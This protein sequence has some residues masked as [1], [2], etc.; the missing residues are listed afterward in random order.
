MRVLQ[1]KEFSELSERRKVPVLDWRAG[2]ARWT[3]RIG[4]ASQDH[5]SVGDMCLSLIGGLGVDSARQYDHRSMGAWPIL[6][7][8][9]AWVV[10]V[11]AFW[12]VVRP[13]LRRLCEAPAGTAIWCFVGKYY[14]RY[15]QSARY[16]GLE[17]IPKTMDPRGMIL[18]SNHV[19]GIDPLLLQ[20]PL[21]THIRWM[22]A[23]DMMVP[24]LRWFWRQERIIPVCYDARDATAIR[25]AIEHLATGGVLGVFPEGAIERPAKQLRPF[26]GGLQLIARRAKCPILVASIDLEGVDSSSPPVGAFA[27]VLRRTR[28]LVRY[29]AYIDP[30]VTPH[31]KD[32]GDLIRQQMQSVLGYPDNPTPIEPVDPAVVNRNLA[33]IQNYARR[34]AEVL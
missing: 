12:L 22:M 30:T 14:L 33:M 26:V 19:S 5:S 24:S 20:L 13:F 7:V 8:L 18:V 29:I 25:T 10:A 15:F 16:A 2:P 9:L 32:V 3:Q 11:G 23:A 28:P 6:L 21:R 17:L 1:L 34:H 31:G 4:Q 27:S